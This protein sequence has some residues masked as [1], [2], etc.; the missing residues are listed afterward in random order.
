M[1]HVMEG[2][3][4]ISNIYASMHVATILDVQVS[5]ETF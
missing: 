4:D 2:T 3:H 1:L 5:E